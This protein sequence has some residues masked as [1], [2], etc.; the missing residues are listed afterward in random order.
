MPEQLIGP[1]PKRASIWWHEISVVAGG[2]RTITIDTSSAFN[3]YVAQA[4]PAINNETSF[5]VLLDAGTYSF[6]RLGR[7]TTS[8][9]MVTI[10]IDGVTVLTNKDWYSAALTRNVIKTTT[11]IVIPTS[12]VHVVRCVMASKNASSSNYG[13]Q[14]QRHWFF[15]ATD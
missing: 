2:A 14:Q 15:P 5:S 12:G 3:H 13:F 10:T 6:S 7:T 1:L 9:G 11:G 4:T 8:L